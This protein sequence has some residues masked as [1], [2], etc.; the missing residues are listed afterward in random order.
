MRLASQRIE[1]PGRQRFGVAD[2]VRHL[3][4]IQAQDFAQALWAVGLRTGGALRE[5][6]LDAL[7]A[8]EV[9]R[10]APLRGTLH[11]V[12]A[13][14]LRWLLALTASRTLAAGATRFRELGLD[15]QTFD[16]AEDVARR[17]L[18]GA[19]DAQG[20]G[21]TRDRFL[22][23]LQSRGIAVDGQRGY[24]IIFY[25]SHRAI[26]CWGPP[27]GT[28]QALVLV[29]DWIATGAQ[30]D[31]DESLREITVRYFTGHGPAA[32]RDLA[33][34]AHLTLADATKGITLALDVLERLDFEG[35]DLWARASGVG[36]A[37]PARRPSRVHL[38]PG[39]D[40]YLIGYQNRAP[41]LAPDL[42]SRVIPGKNG[43]FLPIIV[44][45][46]RVAGT[47]R[48]TPAAKTPDVM[49]DPFRGLTAGETADLHRATRSYLKF[50][51]G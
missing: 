8:G 9:V 24:H 10:T 49:L 36:A 30:L 13:G 27:R 45:G 5:E 40:E 4:A 20:P 16:R 42:A 37:G 34:W 12:A 50:S 23:E 17:V 11:F 1:L 25:L 6:V 41:A 51:A 2:T 43:I 33:R 3:L 35:G 15:Q 48:K 39:F 18:A 7:A 22:A 31:R 29:D 46:G 44:S 38:L 19:G 32:V 14:D 21:L 47:W 26:V 28:Q